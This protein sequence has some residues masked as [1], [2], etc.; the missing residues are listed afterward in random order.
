M[1]FFEPFLEPFYLAA[2]NVFKDMF[3]KDIKPGIIQYHENF[4]ATREANINITIIGD[5]AG[6]VIYSFSKELAFNIISIILGMDFKELN[7][8]VASAVA[9][10]SNIISGNTMT[11]LS[12][13]DCH[14]QIGTPQIFIGTDT[15]IV[16][17]NSIFTIPIKTILGNFEINVSLESR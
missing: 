14:C 12:E 4:I 6:S 17:K 10:I 11:Y 15:R 1:E 5:L 8:F 9:E 13:Q 3:Q 7:Y 2:N 16:T